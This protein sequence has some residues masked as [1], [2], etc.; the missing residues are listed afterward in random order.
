MAIAAQDHIYVTKQKR[1]FW[2]S[3]ATIF[4]ETGRNLLNTTPIF[5]A[6]GTAISLRVPPNE[7]THGDWDLAQS[8]EIKTSSDVFQKE[9]E[10]CGEPQE[11]DDLSFYLNLGFTK[12][13][14]GDLPVKRPYVALK[15]T[16]V[17]KECGTV[18]VMIKVVPKG[19]RLCDAV[20]TTI[21]LENRGCVVYTP[22]LT[23]NQLAE[24]STTVTVFIRIKLCCRY[25]C[26][27]LHLT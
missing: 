2:Q 1:G 8:V 11:I 22:K 4:N 17:P 14:P 7:E 3:C 19:H 21:N 12:A 16:G 13:S 18:K 6:D 15:V 27:L 20:V 9:T 10:V 25:F 23:D 26:V 24:E 5:D